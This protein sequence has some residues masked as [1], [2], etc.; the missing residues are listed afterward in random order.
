MYNIFFSSRS[1]LRLPWT[2]V[3]APWAEQVFGVSSG[4]TT[5]G[6]RPGL[7]QV[8]GLPFIPWER[9][10]QTGRKY[11]PHQRS[12]KLQ[13]TRRQKGRQGVGWWAGGG[14]VYLPR[15]GS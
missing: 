3:R 10:Q 15:K 2:L 14:V 4:R 12:C 9:R 8:H 1:D 11:G 13:G 5:T 6:Y 7:W